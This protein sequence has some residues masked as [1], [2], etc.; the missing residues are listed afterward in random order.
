MHSHLH[1]FIQTHQYA[2]TVEPHL[3]GHPNKGPTPL[4]RPLDNVNI[5]I[6]VLF[7]TSDCKRGV[8]LFIHT[9]F[10]LKRVLFEAQKSVTKLKTYSA[11]KFSGFIWMINLI[12]VCPKLSLN[13][14]D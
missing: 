11:W 3:R 4:E 10:T 9:C 7:S 12:M 2:C 8:P 5:N 6:Y 13:R 1:T 14:V